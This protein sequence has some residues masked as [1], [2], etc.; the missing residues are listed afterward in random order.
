MNQLY[1][2]IPQ[3][4]VSLL[5]FLGDCLKDDPNMNFRESVVDAI[6]EICPSHRE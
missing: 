4:G 2:R 1:H 3:K 6:M 5:K